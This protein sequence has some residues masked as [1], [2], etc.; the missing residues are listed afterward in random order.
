ME[1]RI[2]PAAVELLEPRRLFAM[3]WGA[4]AALIDQDEAAALFPTITGKGVTI[5][6]L[7]TGID[8]NTPALGGGF[9]PGFKVKGGF[10]F[11]DNDADPFDTFGHGTNTASLIA[12]NGFTT[13]SGDYYQGVA[14][15]AQLVA[16][17]IAAGGETVPDATVEQALQWIEQNWQ[18][19][20]IS[21]VNFSFG[22]GRYIDAQTNP[23]L[24]DEFARLAALG[25]LVVCPS[26]NGGVTDGL[27][28]NY[29]AAD[30]NVIAVGS[31]S[32][33]D[34][35]STF[36]QRGPTLD[37]LA[38]GESVGVANRGG[39]F[40][41]LS[42]TSYSPPIIAGAAALLLQADPTLK[43]ADLISILR[44]SGKRI[45]DSTG[46][47]RIMYPR[48][49]VDAA[50]T[51]ALKRAP[52]SGSDVGVGGVGND[53]AYDD[54]GVLHFVYYDERVRTIKYATRSTSGLWS[55]S[56]TID[57][58]GN[59]V[60][61]TLSLAID[62]LGRPSI[63]YYDATEGDLEYARFD[64]KWRRSTLDSKNIGGQFPSLAFDPTGEPVVAYYRK[65]SGDLRVM[66]YDGANWTRTEADTA[67][68][69]GQFASLAFSASGTLGVAYADNTNGDLKY[70][71]W[72]GSGWTTT[73]VDDLNVTAF[74]SLAF[75]GANQP[76]VSYYDAN[77]ANLKYATRATGTWAAETITSKG[78]V[79]L[80]TNLWFDDA[81]MANIVYYNRKS[82]GLFHLIGNAGT[83]TANTLTLLG[84]RYAAASAN[85]DRSAAT[86]SWWNPVKNK[87]M[88]GDIL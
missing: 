74:I 20:D 56:Q 15:E 62:P 32:L 81:N 30:P 64:G 16:L 54:Q 5:A 41:T 52:N 42:A 40:G 44:A 2:C 71:E 82:D 6:Q 61:A 17:R 38:A 11:V 63:A 76:A 51:L 69:V 59:D 37:L 55:A 13:T 66:R 77:P 85:D 7:D 75:D 24:S 22:G 46:G 27:G 26:G 53:L 3:T 12:A 67:G 80:F 78:A 47:T 1:Q 72:N 57:S 50:I 23:T 9:G 8:Y 88:T 19:Y 86:Y 31:V 68:N 34:Q 25:I 60:G 29:P 4:A 10:D 18:T 48:L 21:I 79:G 49:D 58:T 39:T 73:L 35:F 43:R 45:D 70:A 28:L 87:I 65:T 14:P 36:T 33:A 84:G 83:W